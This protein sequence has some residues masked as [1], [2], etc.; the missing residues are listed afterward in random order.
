MAEGEQAD[1]TQKTEEPTPKRLEDA[2]K[3]GQVAISREINNWLML[4]TGTVLIGVAASP[5]MSELKAHLKN[6]IE[7]AHAY[8]ANTLR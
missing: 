1:D 3:K 2:R 6:Y 4:L 7:H 5:M 8:P